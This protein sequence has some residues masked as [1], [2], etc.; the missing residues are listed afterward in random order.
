MRS[1]HVPGAVFPDCSDHPE[2][3]SVVFGSTQ[4]ERRDGGLTP[5]TGDEDAH[6]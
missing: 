2:F 6:P 3:A 1:D 4:D 5:S